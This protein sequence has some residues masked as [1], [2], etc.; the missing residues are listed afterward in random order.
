[1]MQINYKRKKRPAI[2]FQLP[3]LY[4]E[5]PKQ[6]LSGIMDVAKE[7]DVNLIVFPG[8]SPNT[9]KGYEYQANVIYEFINR[10]NVDAL[11]LTTSSICDYINKKEFDA[12]L[13]KFQSLPVVS[14][15]IQ[16]K[17]SPSVLIHNNHA[18]RHAMIHLIEDHG[19]KRIAFI[20]G[21]KNNPEACERYEAYRETLKEHLIPFDE[22]L[23]VPA[24][25][26]GNPE[27]DPVSVLLN[28]R[29]ASFQAIM[30]TNDL[31]ALSAIRS[32]EKLGFHVP[33]D[34]AVVGFDNIPESR[35]NIPSLTTVK[36]PLY[37]QARVAMEMAIN[38]VEG[39]EVPNSLYLP[40]ELMV[41][42]SCGCLTESM[43]LMKET[44]KKDFS[45]I[46]NLDK[47]AAEERKD[48]IVIGI[49]NSIDLKEYSF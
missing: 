5:Y 43:V 9:P 47:R 17:D 23:V 11:V 12:F 8:E 24:N 22:S 18:V 10:N 3:N 30:A 39:R 46:I 4:E 27:N 32:L 20:R 31:M 15:A 44:K 13:K 29:K 16:I 14:I 33:N 19:L 36:Q 38:I 49:I 26:D 21:Y 45:R 25:F 6:L 35:F 37:Q 1:M 28:K 40:T 48:I 2:G 7:R 41:R 34:Y 42:S